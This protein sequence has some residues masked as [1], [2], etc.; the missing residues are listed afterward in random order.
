MAKIKRTPKARPKTRRKSPV[1][2]I[3]PRR[4]AGNPPEDINGYDPVATAGDCVFDRKAAERV[5]AFCER[6]CVHLKGPRAGKPVL[7]EPWQRDVYLTLFGWKRPDG[8]RRYR[9]AFI[10]VSRKNSKTTTFDAPIALWMTGFAG[11]SSAENYVVASKKDQAGVCWAIAAE[12]V[13]KSPTLKREFEIILSQKR[14][15]HLGTG[16]FFAALPADKAGPHGMNPYLIISDET[17]VT[18][19]ALLA[20][21]ETGFGSR[22]DQL[23][24]F[25]TTA[26]DDKASEWWRL[27]QYARKIVAGS[28]ATERDRKQDAKYVDDAGF[29]PVLYE[30]PED[31]E[32]AKRGLKWTDPEA[33]KLSNPNLGIS[34]DPNVVAAECQEAQQDMTREREFRRTRL[35][36]FV[37]AEMKPIRSEQ[38]QACYVPPEDWPNLSQRECFGGLDLGSTQDLTAKALVFPIDGRWWIKVQCYWPPKSAAEGEKEVKAPLGEWIKLGFLTASEGQPYFTDFT[39]VREDLVADSERHKLREL[40]FDPYNANQLMNDL[41][42][43]GIKVVPV[44]QNTKGMN[45]PTKAFIK[46]VGEKRIAHDGNPVVK[47]CIENLQVV[48]DG[49]GNIRPAKPFLPGSD[50]TPDRSKKIDAAVAI[51]TAIARLIVPEPVEESVYSSRDMWTT[52]DVE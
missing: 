2:R 5:I 34:I 37:E 13:E 45:E 23:E 47:W 21:I 43:F 35:N 6:F 27:L 28:Q 41:D 22:H 18:P 30:T 14:I 48:A 12:M 44:S 8:R 15:V 11:E 7:L 42:A 16:S 40:G 29:L 26:G 19:A 20:A 49:F 38:W 1:A 9:K 32:L 25:T 39:R 4:Y 24:L 17:H 31:A 50:R 51:I 52:D 3:K 36:Q 33:W 46:A 10:T